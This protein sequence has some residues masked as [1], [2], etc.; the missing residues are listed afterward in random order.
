MLSQ[1]IVKANHYLSIKNERKG[2]SIK[3]QWQTESPN[4]LL[5]EFQ[6]SS[7]SIY[8]PFFKKESPR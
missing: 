2:S 1:L 7:E 6:A 5:L 3:K 8:K 4:I